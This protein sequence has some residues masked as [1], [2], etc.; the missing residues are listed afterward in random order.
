MRIKMSLEST[1]INLLNVPLI[2]QRVICGFEKT[3]SM[4]VLLENQSS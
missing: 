2:S 4:G 3:R 1:N